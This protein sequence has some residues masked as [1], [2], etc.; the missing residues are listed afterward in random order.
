[1][2][3]FDYILYA[4]ATNL[5]TLIYSA[6][7]AR[8]LTLEERGDWGIIFIYSSIV[9][10]LVFPP[11]LDYLANEIYEDKYLRGRVFEILMQLIA[12]LF[13]PISLISCLF[14]RV[15]HYDYWLEIPLVALGLVLHSW[16]VG[17]FLQTS[18]FR[19]LYILQLISILIQTSITLILFYTDNMNPRYLALTYFI[20]LTCQ[21]IILLRRLKAVN[22]ASDFSKPSYL[23]VFIHKN[24]KK[25][26]LAYFALVS[27]ILLDG[28]PKI[29]L[30]QQLSLAEFGKVIVI[31]QFAYSSF[32]IV[33]SIFKSRVYAL[34]ANKND[35]QYKSSK[36]FLFISAIYFSGT[37]FALIFGK[38]LVLLIFGAKFTVNYVVWV[39]ICGFA[40]SASVLRLRF[41]YVRGQGRPK[42]EV[43][44]FVSVLI[45]VFFMLILSRNIEAMNILVIVNFMS[46]MNITAFLVS[47]ISNKKVRK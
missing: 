6:L 42:I 34:S 46:L 43:L 30:S 14:L 40:L 20:A 19:T 26:F 31:L 7:V 12:Y 15:I 36:I 41:D 3:K 1:L 10:T 5:I 37:I 44:S 18:R 32:G 27:V 9:A 33:N 29:Y 16:I 45:F 22:K 47:W 38:D 8:G 17:V 35:E 13:F 11:V 28:F 24:I 39:S 21:S 25:V 2:K 23:G 4:V